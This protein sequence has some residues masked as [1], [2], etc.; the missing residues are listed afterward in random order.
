MVLDTATKTA[1]YRAELVSKSELSR[2]L[3]EYPWDTAQ[4]WT[5][6]HRAQWDA[7]HLAA[8][9]KH[10]PRLRLNVNLTSIEKKGSTLP[11]VRVYN[12][13][14]GIHL[15]VRFA[16]YGA[17]KFPVGDRVYKGKGTT[18]P[19][20]LARELL[21]TVP[22]AIRRRFRIR[23]LAD[24]GFEAAVF[25]DEVWHL[26]FEFVVGVRSTRQTMH[27]GGAT[28]ADCPH[29]GYVELKN[30]PH[31]TLVLGRV[32]RG[33][34][35]FHAVSSALMAGDEVIAEGKARWNEESF[36]KRANSSS[37]GA[38]LW[39]WTVGSAWS[40]SRGRWRSCTE[41]PA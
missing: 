20:T 24:S 36:L 3:N 26:G 31:G 38:L 33:D 5:I 8:R 34:R 1:L 9:R 7:L 35:T 37:Q 15:I 23:V 16:Q 27:P 12:N 21:R 4:G 40:S 11:F 13:V 10:R 18:T 32:D 22:D 2:L 6:L 25:L 17:V 19:V 41:R 14:H 30:W 39:D 28:V 29:G